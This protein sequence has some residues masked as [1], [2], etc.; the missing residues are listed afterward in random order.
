[1]ETLT[2]THIEKEITWGQN[3]AAIQRTT[4]NPYIIKNNGS[5]DV[6]EWAEK[7]RDKL[8]KLLLK[9]G[10]ILLR[11]FEIGGAEKFNRLFSIISGD[12]MEYKNRTSPRDQVFENV[13]TSTSHP[14]DQVIHMHTENSYSNTFNRIIAFYSLLPA[15][16][17]GETPIAD[18]RK[19]LEFLKPETIEKFRDKGVQYVRNSMPGIGLSWETIYQTNDK[20]EVEKIL[21]SAGY[22]YDWID[23][24]HL[25]IKWTLPAFQ[26]HPITGEEMWF[27]HMFFGNKNLY[28]P[29]ILEYFEEENLPFVTYF[30]DGEPIDASIIEEFKSFYREN[31]IVFKWQKD[32]FLLLDNMMFS[33]GRNSF[34]GERITL[35]AMAQPHKI[36]S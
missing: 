1:M 26:P 5:T 35:T 28:D 33:H 20:S 25:R 16:I 24:D 34:E 2:N 36:K 23:T 6:L 7:N 15:T 12:A 17:G 29:A 3:I 31:S 13:Y 4:N 11:G 22:D 14:K 27:N 32:D 10:A 8:N 30:G 9:E 19:L 21:N 18:E